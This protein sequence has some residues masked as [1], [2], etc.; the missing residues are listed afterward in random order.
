MGI[1]GVVTK[2]HE[3]EGGIKKERTKIKEHPLLYTQIVHH[4]Y[5]YCK[6]NFVYQPKM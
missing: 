5:Q 4:Q 2:L 3:I 6:T 1:L